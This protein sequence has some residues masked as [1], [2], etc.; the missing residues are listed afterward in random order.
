M[1]DYSGAAAGNGDDH[2]VT[3][4]HHPGEST[5]DGGLASNCLTLL[6]NVNGCISTQAFEG[7]LDKRPVAKQFCVV[8]G[9]QPLQQ[10]VA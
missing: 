1:S 8:K 2:L 4:V 3:A 10:I 9:R 5:G 6:T 7:G